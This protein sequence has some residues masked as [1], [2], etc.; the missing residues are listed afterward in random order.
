MQKVHGDDEAA[1]EHRQVT[2]LKIQAE[3]F[4]PAELSLKT[5][6]MLLLL[7]S[8]RNFGALLI[9]GIFF[10]VILHPALQNMWCKYPEENR[11]L[12]VL[13][14]RC[15]LLRLLVGWVFGLTI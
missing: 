10:P 15:A 6:L 8:R 4:Q 3:L 5:V 13:I 7:L 14:R 9:A 1:D 12:Q 11:G 2:G